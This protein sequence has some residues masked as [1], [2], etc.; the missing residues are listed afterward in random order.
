LPD[1]AGRLSPFCK[2]ALRSGAAGWCATAQES[3]SEMPKRPACSR[4]SRSLPG[5]P[6]MLLPLACKPRQ[7]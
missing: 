7:E 3:A 6:G 5:W 2:A 4:L 1:D